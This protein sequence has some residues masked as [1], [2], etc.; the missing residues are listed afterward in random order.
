VDDLVRAL[1]ERHAAEHPGLVGRLSALGLEVYRR[2]W[3]PARLMARVAP[4]AIRRAM[5]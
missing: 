1:L 5:A 3:F 4:A 2:G